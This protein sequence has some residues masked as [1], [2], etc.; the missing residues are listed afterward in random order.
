M[1]SDVDLPQ[2]PLYPPARMFPT[3]EG[4][5]FCQ[6]SKNSPPARDP[7]VVDG[8]ADKVYVVLSTSSVV[9]FL[10]IAPVSRGHVLICPRAHDETIADVKSEEAAVLGFWLPILSRGVMTGVFG[11]EDKKGKSWN[12]VQANGE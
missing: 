7:Q 4:C 2:S 11:K 12:L 8:P 1:L 5:A 3:I 9:A 10:D 6:I